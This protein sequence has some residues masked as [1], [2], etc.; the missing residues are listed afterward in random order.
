MKIH[1]KLISL[2]FFVCSSLGVQAQN[3]NSN[4]AKSINSK[5]T[6]FKTNYCRFY[7]NSVTYVNLG[8]PLGVFTLGVIRH[9][10][11][12]QNNAAYMAG[13]FA[14]S[15]VLTNSAKNIF[16][17]QRPYE[18]Y[19]EITKLSSGGGYSFPSGHTSA[20][21]STATSLSLCYPKWYIITPAYIWAG[22]VSIARIYQG[23]HYPADI[24]AGALIG[25]GSAYASYKLQ[26]WMDRKHKVKYS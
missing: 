6:I 12:M 21:F 10:K 14:L 23:V 26:K 22:S 2:G 18:K 3:L 17:E 20:A 1:H 5:Q 4:I 16:K 8:V 13:A 25:S 9:D 24:L 15:S 19:P 7:A 11:N